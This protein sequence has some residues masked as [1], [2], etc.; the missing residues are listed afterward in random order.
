MI[1][2]AFESSRGVF[3]L[4]AAAAAAAVGEQV[5]GVVDVRSTVLGGHLH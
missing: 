2:C 4:L 3:G 5:S 1:L